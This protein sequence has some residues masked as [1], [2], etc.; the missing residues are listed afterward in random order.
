MPKP[1]L[2]AKTIN[3]KYGSINY[4]NSLRAQFL[5]LTKKF[6]IMKIKTFLQGLF[7]AVIITLISS[8]KEKPKKYRE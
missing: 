3:I 5:I 6:I 8:C 1:H 7:I 2:L 4:S